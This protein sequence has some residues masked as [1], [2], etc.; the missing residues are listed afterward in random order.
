[1]NYTR[2]GVVPRRI[3][4]AEGVHCSASFNNPFNWP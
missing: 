4:A 1:L 3:D 2:L